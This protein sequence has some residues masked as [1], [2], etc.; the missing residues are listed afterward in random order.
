[1]QPSY[2]TALSWDLYIFFSYQFI[3]SAADYEGLCS[4][5]LCGQFRL[6]LSQERQLDCVLGA[7]HQWVYIQSS[8]PPPPTFFPL[9]CLWV[10]SMHHF[11]GRRWR[12][13]ANKQALFPEFIFSKGTRWGGSRHGGRIWERGS[14]GQQLKTVALTQRDLC[15]LLAKSNK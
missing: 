2:L 6:F 15:T 11:R 5:R 4:Q 1:M 12:E 8:Y 9:P 7:W 10:T 3:E 14:C 13:K